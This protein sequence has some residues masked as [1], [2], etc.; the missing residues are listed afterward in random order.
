MSL[1]GLESEKSRCESLLLQ[2]SK[3]F[4]TYCF[5]YPEAV[6]PYK[7]CRIDELQSALRLDANGRHLAHRVELP[8][9]VLDHHTRRGKSLLNAMVAPRW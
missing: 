7:S 5:S 2:R 4:P 9:H 1:T 6:F 3:I 8:D